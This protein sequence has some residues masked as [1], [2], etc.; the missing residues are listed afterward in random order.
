[1]LIKLPDHVMSFA[2]YNVTSNTS[3]MPRKIA[4]SLFLCFT[5]FLLHFNT[6]AQQWDWKNVKQY[7]AAQGL[8]EGQVT[9]IVIDKK[10]LGW[11]TTASGM[12][13]YDG[14]KFLPAQN[15][16]PALKEYF[17]APLLGLLY[18]EDQD[19]IW[20]YSQ[21]EVFVLRLRLL[22]TALQRNAIR[23]FYKGDQVMNGAKSSSGILLF[24][25]QSVVV[26]AIPGDTSYQ[27]YP[28]IRG[29][30]PG[31]ITAHKDSI[32]IPVGTD[33]WSIRY[34]MFN[35]QTF[36]K[37]NVTFKPQ[38]FDSANVESDKAKVLTNFYTKITLHTPLKFNNYKRLLL[39]SLMQS[40]SGGNGVAADYYLYDFFNYQNSIL[41]LATKFGLYMVPSKPVSS[42]GSV[43]QSSIR[44]VFYN[45]RYDK[46]LYCTGDGI[47]AEKNSGTPAV[48]FHFI[49]GTGASNAAVQWDQSTWIAFSASPGQP[50]QTY[51]YDIDHDTGTV[52]V[53]P[54]LEVPFSCQKINNQLWSGGSS[55]QV[56][57]YK[58]KQF[59]NTRTI[60][61]S[62]SIYN[63][64]KPI[65][66]KCLVTAANG[67]Y[68]M[69]I[70]SY[71]KRQ[72]L[73]GTFFCITNVGEAGWAAG[74]SANGLFI[75]DTLGKVTR[76]LSVNDGLPHPTI[77]NITYDAKTKILWCG[78]K[79]GLVSFSLQSGALKTF[80]TKDGLL[81][82]EFNINANY[83]TTDN[84][85]YE[86]GPKGLNII[87][88]EKFT[89][90]PAPLRIGFLSVNGSG[91]QDKYTPWNLPGA[92][93]LKPGIYTVNITLSGIDHN[94][95]DIFRYRITG[96]V[97]QTGWQIKEIHSP[98][99]LA[100]L[101]DGYYTIEVE[102]NDPA[103]KGH[104][105]T[106]LS[107]HIKKTWYQ[108]VVF[109]IAVIVLLIAGFTALFIW[110]QK[111]RNKRI[112]MQTLLIQNQL[113]AIRAQINP[114]F[115]Q[116]MFDFVVQFI[117]NNTVE[118]SA[119]TLKVIAK[120]LNQVLN[121]NEQ[122]QIILQ[123]ELDHLEL[124]LKIQQLIHPGLFD[125]S[126]RVAQMADTHHLYVPAMLL[127]PVVENCIKHGF[128]QLQKGG[129]IQINVEKENGLIV[130]SIKDNGNGVEVNGSTDDNTNVNR[131]SKG[132]ELTEKRLLLS[133]EKSNSKN[134]AAT[135]RN[136]ED[137]KQGSEFLIQFPA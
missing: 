75:I 113:K 110:W 47:A 76:H 127:Q 32:I 135:L 114:H 120:Y 21:N 33:Q 77:Y 20:F 86:G 87:P 65:Q 95:R 13:I 5:F 88:L 53:N 92:L 133:L 25:F 64:S 11:V 90:H 105:F 89:G 96:D 109:R 104:S 91:E 124:Y 61:T 137:G 62:E 26:A 84:I 107:I 38:Y 70:N 66:N 37:S 98:I 116:N 44:S 128:R 73:D 74:S 15:Y 134:I 132:I 93:E 100:G 79:Q 58:D 51:I 56:S 82:N 9:G 52:Q 3:F 12:Y 80:T 35:E 126:I 36:D 55:L 117:K 30:I 29:Y 8:F 99:E 72:I 23:H 40:R 101:G 18:V 123:E 122:A 85:L 78:T 31:I 83:L 45:D 27:P 16:F 131:Q 41:W 48:Q 108:T 112:E 7:G 106:I 42:P 111:N 14:N 34:S 59:I 71:A 94:Y 118:H 24:N 102:N 46:L 19:E 69:D 10:K 63:I 115:I 121:M 39:D 68:F 60:L 130:I 81:D 43:F 4:I 67:L 49:A 129:F 125:Y 57:D 97:I 17:S 50:L 103:E 22:N 136:R 6:D 54:G 2:R 1:M 119:K 28:L